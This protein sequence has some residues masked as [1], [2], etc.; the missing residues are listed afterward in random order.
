MI[1]P[2]TIMYIAFD[3]VA[4]VA[5]LEQQRNRRYKSYLLTFLKNEFEKQPDTWDKTAIT[6]GTN[7]MENLA[8]YTKHYYHNK[9]KL[10]NISSVPLHI[11]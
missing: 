10:Y 5:K 7:F 11:S 3:G 8:N 6:P 2:T 1:K 4:P 9:E